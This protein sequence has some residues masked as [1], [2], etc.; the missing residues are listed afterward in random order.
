MFTD[1]VGYTAL[2]QRD[3]S[4]SLALVEEQR[5]LIRPIL[6]RHNGREVKTI[7]D[8]FLV[9][10]P[11]TVDAVRCAYD[12]QRAIREFNLSLSADRRIHLRI[13]VHAGEVVESFG[14]ISGDAVNVASRIET[15]AEDG[16]VCVTRQV[17]ENV[18]NKVDLILSSLGPKSLKNVAMPVEVYKMVMPWETKT[19]Y[20]GNT[21]EARRIAVLPFASLSP[22]PNDEYFADGLTEELITKISL[23]GGLEVIA[24]TSVMGFK[25]KDKKV[26]EIATEL[27]VGT[28][29]EGSVRKAGNRI[30]VTA[31][32]INSNTEGHIWAE[33][34]DR[35]LDDI[36]A[37]QSDVAT[38]VAESIPNAIL[39][40][41]FKKEGRDTS[42]MLGYTQFLRG[43]QLVNELE[44]EPLRQALNLFEEAT[45]R[46]PKFARAYVGIAR[47][48][49]WLADG[50]Y[51]E[52]QEAI[53]KGRSAV[54]KAVELNP[55]LGEAHSSLTH[56]MMMADESLEVQKAQISK[57]LELNPNLEDAYRVLANL[58]CGLGNTAEMVEA[59]EKAYQLNPLSPRSIDLI[60]TVYFAAG[61]SED[62]FNHW[63]K[64]L[65]LEPYRTHRRMFDYYVNKGDLDQAEKTVKE[66][67][68]IGPT[69]EYTYLNRGFLAASTGD[70][71][72][73]REMIDK[74]DSTHKPGWARSSSAGFIYL[75]LGDLDAFFDYMFRAVDD[76]TLPISLNSSFLRYNPLVEKARKD[77]RFAE[78]FRRA[79]LPYEPLS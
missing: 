5:K 71:R 12:I 4:L 47:C 53:D 33:S 68:R 76:H 1:M 66:L 51:I 43:M 9:E 54:M 37:V 22:D 57:A 27:N 52:W 24:R 41:K 42:D 25:K 20:S 30:R 78:V 72:T 67:E 35:N 45:S 40:S 56:I 29:L 7:G 38:R 46:D 79:G 6:K 11:N 55:D 61:R 44:Q 21:L 74:L 23:V 70:R 15:L 32:L 14:D 77:A 60:G 75:A 19:T 49:I 17:H 3:E 36:F 58:S 63:M 48:Y 62:A 50:G 39:T 8:A 10:F 26:S 34:Y 73:A 65:Y 28:I 31:Q 2:G 64:T 69:L 59:A 16:G 13:G 18:R